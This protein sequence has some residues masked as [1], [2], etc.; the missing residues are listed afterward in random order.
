MTVLRV[1]DPD[2]IVARYLEETAA[3]EYDGVVG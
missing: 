3:G 1:P 2:I